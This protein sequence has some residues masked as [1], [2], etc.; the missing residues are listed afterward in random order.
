MTDAS[1]GLLESDLSFYAK[2]ES[3]EEIA[4][5]EGVDVWEPPVD[6][7]SRRKSPAGG[8]MAGSPKKNSATNNV[9]PP[10]RP[11]SSVRDSAPLATTRGSGGASAGSAASTGKTRA[12]RF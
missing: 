5:P 12:V 7:V 6:P 2:P 1:S 3:E 9:N 11:P 8:A 10:V 4:V